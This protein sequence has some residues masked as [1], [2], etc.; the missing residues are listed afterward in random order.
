MS[1]RKLSAWV[2]AVSLGVGAGCTTD[3]L[4]VPAIP[5][6]EVFAATLAGT[7]EVPVVTTAASGTARIVIVADT[8]LEISV[9]VSAIDSTTLSHIHAGAA[10]VNGP[11]IVTLYTGASACKQ[12]AGTAIAITSSSV[13]NPT[14]I[15][16]A[17]HGQAIGSTPFLRIAGHTGSTPSL[18]N[19]YT[20]TVTGATT[21]TVPVNVTVAGAGG[22]AQ[23]FTFINGTSPR[24]KV[25]Y[26]GPL[27]LRQFTPRQLTDAGIQSYGTTPR[28]RF[29]SLLS[30]LRTG[31]A[32]V[33]VHNRANPGGHVRGQVFPN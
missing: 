30:L 22:T 18:D 8:F 10:G 29:D 3:P 12:N 11:V 24:C 26:T 13:G 17:A 27:A 31:D 21:Y 14:T 7:E 19:E 23:R 28:A 2:I 1:F 20:A 5:A 4:K 16:T 33:N 15:T 9:N 32:Y 25:G 6:D